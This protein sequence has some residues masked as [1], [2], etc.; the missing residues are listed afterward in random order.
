MSQSKANMLP[1]PAS[2]QSTET[3]S[4]AVPARPAARSLASD[5]VDAR[6]IVRS[7]ALGAVLVGSVFGIGRLLPVATNG[8]AAGPRHAA[9][10][11]SHTRTAQSI[12]P[13]SYRSQAS[14]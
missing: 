12:K 9:L 6:L 2:W 4:E 8:S 11:A 14:R 5:F 7:L 10:S 1:M 13:V 3:S